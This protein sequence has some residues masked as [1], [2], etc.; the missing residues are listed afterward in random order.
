[1]KLL[2]IALLCLSLCG[3]AFAYTIS[4]EQ[5][6]LHRGRFERLLR[7]MKMENMIE[8]EREWG[9]LSSVYTIKIKDTRAEAL[10]AEFQRQ[11]KRI[12]SEL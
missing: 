12:N 6:A 10:L 5:G 11:A 9:F 8:Y 3:N 4:T 1:M 2:L 7:M